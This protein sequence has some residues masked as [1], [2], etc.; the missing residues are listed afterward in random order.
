MLW[1]TLSWFLHQI[2]FFISIVVYL[3]ALALEQVTQYQYFR[4]E[5]VGYGIV[6]LSIYLD[7]YVYRYELMYVKKVEG[8]NL[9]LFYVFVFVFVYMFVFVLWYNI[10]RWQGSTWTYLVY[11]YL[12]LFVCLYLYYNIMPNRWRGS[13][14]TWLVSP[15]S[16]SA[17][18]T[19]PQ[20]K[21][22]L[23]C[24]VGN[25]VIFCDIIN[26]YWCW[27]LSLFLKVAPQ[28][29]WKRLSGLMCS[30]W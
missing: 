10:K 19:P 3:P 25:F 28:E 4:L 18:S 1:R 12:F 2:L 16:S 23:N 9:D 20:V 13:T 30:S 7:I 29:V 17:S 26:W 24:I 6:I 27:L 22:I 15:S 5:E 8:V 14:W 11:L 21:L